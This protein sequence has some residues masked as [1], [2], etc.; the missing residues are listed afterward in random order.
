MIPKRIDAALGGLAQQ[1]LELGEHLLDR[2]EVRRVWRLVQD[3]GAPG[4]DGLRNAA[5]LVAGQVVGNDDVPG[6]ERGAQELTHP[7]QEHLSV[8]GAIDHQRGSHTIMAQ[9]S[10]ER[11]G[12]P[13]P[14]RGRSH[15]ALAAPGAPVAACHVR[16]GG[17]LIQKDQPVWLQATLPG[18]PLLARLLYVGPI[19]LAGVQRFF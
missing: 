19:L 7:G 4:S 2:I 16:A 17:R 6:V 10:N 18:P 5:D 3:A 15:A 12:L 11:G 14:M 8:H 9:A 1:R 13:M